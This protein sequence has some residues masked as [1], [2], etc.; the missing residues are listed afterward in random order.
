[1]VAQYCECIGLNTTK[2]YTYKGLKCKL[3]GCIFYHDYI[4]KNLLYSIYYTI[5]REY[6]AEYKVL[7][8]N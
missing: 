3:Y 1:M 7:F 4:L 6:R 2:L 8:H 5:F